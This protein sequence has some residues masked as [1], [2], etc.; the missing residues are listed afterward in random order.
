MLEEEFDTNETPLD[1]IIPSS[2]PVNKLYDEDICVATPCDSEETV[3]KSNEEIIEQYYSYLKIVFEKNEAE[4]L[5]PH[6]DIAIKLIPGGQ[7][8]FGPTYSITIKEL[9]A[10]REYIIDKL[11]KHFIP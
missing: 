6:Y 5:L 3:M 10:L 8:Y 7:I 9:E 11:R 4:K 2:I 1:S